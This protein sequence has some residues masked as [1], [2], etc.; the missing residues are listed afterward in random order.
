MDAKHTELPWNAVTTGSRMRGYGQPYAIAENNAPNLI[1]GVF[2]DVRGGGPVAEANAEY[3]VL[4]VNSHAKL[5]EALEEMLRQYGHANT[6]LESLESDP[7]RQALEAARA[8]LLAAGE[9]P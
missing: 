1:A 2:G 6:T 4:C 8:A 5:V 7:R 9:K 3:I